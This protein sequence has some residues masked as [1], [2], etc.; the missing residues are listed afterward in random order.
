MALMIEP[1][2]PKKQPL[3][4][5][6]KPSGA[7]KGFGI[8]LVFVALLVW[9]PS[10][11]NLYDLGGSDAAG[12]AMAQGFAAIALILLWLLLA[13]LALL[14]AA[15]GASPPAA[16]LAALV[17]VPASG[18]AALE[19]LDLLAKPETPP[20]NWPLLVPVV[21]PLLIALVSLTA[22]L[23]RPPIAR[24]VSA[25]AWAGVLIVSAA[26]LPLME[27]RR[28]ADEATAAAVAAKDAA[29]AALPAD[30]PLWALVP[31]LDTPNLYR[32]SDVIDRIRAMGRRQADAETMIDR[33]DFPL[34][35]LR[36]IDLD[37]TPA[38][39]E[40]TRAL[41]MRQVRPLVLT[42]SGS[43]PYGDVALQVDGAATAME[44]LVGFSCSCDAESKAWEDM[45][46]GYR[47]P[48]FDVVRLRE[49]RDPK[50]LGRVLREDPPRFSMLGPQSHLKAWLKFTDDKELRDRA[51]AGAR[52]LDHRTPDAVEMLNAD[53]FTAARVLGYLPDLDLEAT[54]PLCEAALKWL[55]QDFA[56]TYRPSADDPRSYRELL[57]RLGEGG[58]FEELAWLA[59]HGCDAGTELDQADSLIRTYQDSPERS[60]MLARL[61]GLKHK[62]R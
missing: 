13:A 38:L 5:E 24:T 37:P 35:V 23:A 32:R 55:D 22:L 53:E 57:E 26:I 2:G 9:L 48:S 33:G 15:K 3:M 16:S 34:L 49:L 30:A 20:H 56:H 31:F 58:P 21:A 28:A 59:G 4:A 39:C 27:S 46:N 51:L 45:A 17:L 42:E 11:A 40:K 44:W 50:A 60:A 36:E 62:P 10:M 29:Y 52:A 25:V 14:A 8:A 12:N 19:A 43:K 47:D 1:S 18:A 61:A 7:A 41:L 54:A 6:P